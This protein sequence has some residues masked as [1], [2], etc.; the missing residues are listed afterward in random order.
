MLKVSSNPV[1]WVAAALRV[2]ATT[3]ATADKLA[4]ME[5]LC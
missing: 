2:S 3:A 5:I 1:A 4:I